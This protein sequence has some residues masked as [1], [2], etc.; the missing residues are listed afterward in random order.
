[1]NFKDLGEMLEALDIA[2]VSREYDARLHIRFKIGNEEQC[3]RFLQLIINAV[4]FLQDENNWYSALK[5]VEFKV[6]DIVQKANL[7]FLFDNDLGY[8]KLIENKPLVRQ[9]AERTNGKLA[10]KLY[11]YNAIDNRQNAEK[12]RSILLYL[13]D[14]T[15]PITKGYNRA[16]DIGNLYKVLDFALNNCDVR[17]NNKEGSKKNNFV[18]EL[19]DE[20]LVEVYD[21]IFDLFLQVLSIENTSKS[22]DYIEEIKDK[23]DQKIY[24]HI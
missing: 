1:M 8:Y 15:E 12:K 20:Q 16:G 7:D 13:A 24:K 6:K 4:K 22:L 9:I 10:Y 11:E 23:F 5:V 2:Y 21:R 17:H 19:T 3:Y 18:S 14:Y